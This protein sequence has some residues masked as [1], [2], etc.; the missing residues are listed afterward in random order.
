MLA[1][2]ILLSKHSAIVAN[3]KC[4]SCLVLWYLWVA[5]WNSERGLLPLG[6]G[7][8]VWWFV[9]SWCV[10]TFEFDL[11]LSHW[12]VHNLDLVFGICET[13]DFF[14]WERAIWVYLR[15]GFVRV[16]LHHI[17]II[18][19]LLQWNLFVITMDVGYCWIT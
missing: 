9:L 4:F 13:L 12:F 1:N 11:W 3:R 2:L 14:L 7:F 15:F 6:F 5:I 8:A 16:P 19:N 17:C 18:P 10:A